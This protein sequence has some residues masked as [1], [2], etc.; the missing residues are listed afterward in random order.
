LAVIVAVLV[1]A[2]LGGVAGMFLAV[3]TMAI[4]SVIFR[5]WRE[6]RDDNSSQAPV[7]TPI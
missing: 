4:G 5:H 6:W 3:P 7:Q 1:G 2:E